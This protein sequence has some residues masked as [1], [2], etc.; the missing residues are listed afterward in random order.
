MNAWRKLIIK[1]KSTSWLLVAAVL[2]LTLLPAH[3]HV[4]HQSS[5]VTSAHTHTVD[6]HTLSNTSSSAHHDGSE[7]NFAATPDGVIKKQDS[8]FDLSLVLTVFLVSLA[9]L[10][11]R[12]QVRPFNWYIPLKRTYLYFSPPL[13]AP[14]LH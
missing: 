8:I 3:Y 6:L 4:H 2:A 1:Y 10:H 11:N 5:D 9:L 7:V 13:R 14:P 12:T